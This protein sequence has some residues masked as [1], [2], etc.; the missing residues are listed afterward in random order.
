MSKDTTQLNTTASQEDFSY[1]K[2]PRFIEFMK[3]RVESSY[4][5]SRLIDGH[6][7][8]RQICEKLGLHI[9]DQP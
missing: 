5:R 2:D 4:D 6:A 1:E 9:Y 7:A 8:T 3:S